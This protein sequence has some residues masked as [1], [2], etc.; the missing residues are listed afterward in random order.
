MPNR[1][2][3]VAIELGTEA[4]PA[5]APLRFEVNTLARALGQQILAL[6][7]SSS[8]DLADQIRSSVKEIRKSK[9]SDGAP[10]APG[11]LAEVLRKRIGTLS[12]KDAEDLVSAFSLYFHLINVAEERQRARV[13]AERESNSSA[14]HP[15]RESLMSMVGTLKHNG[16]SYEQAVDLL[17]KVQLHLTFTAHPTETRR[18]TVRQQLEQIEQALERKNL[19]ELNARIGLLWSTRELRKSRPSVQDEVRGSLHYLPQVLWLTLPR[20]VDGLEEAVHA[21]YGLRPTLPPP[22]VFRSWI[23]GDRDGNPNVVAEVTQWAQSF[24]RNQASQGYLRELELLVR[25]LSLSTERV[26]IP[27]ALQIR[28]N[29]AL[30]AL[31]SADRLIDEPLRDLCRL[32]Q[33]RL[34]AN[35]TGE[36][37]SYATNEA[38]FADISLLAESLRA[39]SLPD[40]EQSFVRPFEV[41]ARTFGLDL[42]TLDLRE[43]SRAHTEAVAELFACS[44]LTESYATLNAVDREA[45]LVTELASRRPLAPVG[46]QPQSRALRVALESLRAWKAHGAYVVS[47]TRS[48]ADMLEVFLLAREVGLYTPGAALPFDVVPLFETLADLEN[49]PA[50]VN[51]L[52]SQ[53]VFAAHV[54][55]R[56]GLEVM[57]G[58]SDSNKDAGFLAAN[59]ALYRA[60]EEIAIQA[61]RH[62]VTVWFFHGRGT[63]TAR[64]GGSAGRALASLP[65]GTVGYRMRLTEQ[66]EA[67]SD[68]YS[69][70]EFAHR[71]LEQ[72]LYH[73]S[74]AAARDVKGE[75]RDVSTE[76]VAAMDDAA[77]TS[78]AAYRALLAVPG[79]F[80][81][82]EQ[83]T[84]IREIGAL[85]IASRP[86]YRSG[87]VRELR[88]LRAIPWVM[89]WTQVRLPVPSFFGVTEGLKQL[90]VEVRRKMLSQWPFFASTLDSAATALGKADLLVAEEYL[91]LVEPGLAQTFYP[92]LRTAF[93]EGRALLEETFETRLLAKHPTLA[94]QIDLRNP[95]VDPIG[96]IQ[97]E[98]LR[99]LRACE[100][101]D[102]ERASLE[103][104][105]MGS[106]VGVAAGVRNAG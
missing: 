5:P 68:R 30:S 38:L 81:F 11:S 87:R 54:R 35:E 85:K 19:K 55:S 91:S 21:H 75:H 44:G 65:P 26:K 101:D 88:D 28:L 102:P 41:R 72:L 43:E 71:H 17:S 25:D 37:E 51:R 4:A 106:L 6:S 104:A 33:F 9:N 56:G 1:D 98:L 95:Y 24:A 78:T 14:Q 58:Y 76:W 59:W 69:H 105:L 31:P 86:V 23:G 18:R 57:I 74:L 53:P 40:A 45:L 52:L 61:K 79:F 64:G 90:P 83:F 100:P 12:T 20:L 94:R 73:L 50:T 63:S 10:P 82:Y 66:G 8:F 70:P 29:E 92:M 48:A 3:D 46:W 15:R 36:A 103:R 39:L 97:V 13:N 96:R 99:R 7:G 2:I 60:Q 62:G 22:V 80:E 27:D 93:D 77:K 16:F 32:M 49:A 47:M 89:S 67:L 34:R 42:V 84:P